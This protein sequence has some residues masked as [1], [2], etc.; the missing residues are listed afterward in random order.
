MSAGLRDG[1]KPELQTEPGLAQLNACLV[2]LLTQVREMRREADPTAPMTAEELCRRWQIPGETPKNQLFNLAR[3]CG[4]YGREAAKGTRGWEALFSRSD[5][6]ATEAFM[7]G[8]S[9]RRRAA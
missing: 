2:T 1:L 8:K 3:R 6:L 5:V 7:F 4:M 9:K